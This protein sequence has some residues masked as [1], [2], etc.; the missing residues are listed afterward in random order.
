MGKEPGMNWASAADFWSMGGA[1]FYVWGSYAVAALAI[2]F[3]AVALRIRRKRA[4]AA[5]REERE[6]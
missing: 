5:I 1:G 2:A 6:L 3:E 4:L